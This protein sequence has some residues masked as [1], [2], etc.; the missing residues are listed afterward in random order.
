MSELIHFPDNS[1]GHGEKLM[2]DA[3]LIRDDDRIPSG[4]SLFRR[5]V[6]LLS[7]KV[8][9]AFYSTREGQTPDPQAWEHS[10][11]SIIE[12][13]IWAL[14]VPEFADH[15]TEDDDRTQEIGNIMSY[16]MSQGL[17][18]EQVLECYKQAFSIGR[19]K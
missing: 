12:G 13:F 1:S 3:S 19:K 11:V 10:S 14:T 17:T 8:E 7:G 5:E 6:C 18:E 15:E 16:A 4:Y 2:S 9:P